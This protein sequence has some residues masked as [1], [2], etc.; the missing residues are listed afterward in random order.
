[1]LTVAQH[2][3]ITGANI[4][5]LDAGNPLIKLYLAHRP[6]GSLHLCLGQSVNALIFAALVAFL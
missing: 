3:E 1:M 4:I 6:H 2:A 5:V